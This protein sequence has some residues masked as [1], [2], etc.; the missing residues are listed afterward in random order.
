MAGMFGAPNGITAYNAD[1]RAN[2]QT[3]V[4]AL[5]GLGRVAMQPDQAR[6]LK[7]RADAAEL[8]VESENKMNALMQAAM[9]GQQGEGPQKPRSLASTLDDLAVAA[10]GAGMS[11]KAQEL[12]KTAAG[13]HQKEASAAASL[14]NAAVKRLQFA[15]D[16]A[17]TDAQILGSATDPASWDYANQLYKM[18]TGRPSPYEGQPFDPSLIQQ[19]N[20]AAISAK[21]RASQAE[22]A[23]AHQQLENYR[24][25]RLKQFDTANRIRALRA[26]QAAKREQR[27]E[28]QG[29]GSK[30]ASPTNRE[31]TQTRRL[32]VQQYPDMD[33]ADVREAAFA[34][35]SEAQ[36][37]RNANHALDA[38]TAIRQALNNNASAFLAETGMSANLPLI[39][40]V[41]FGERSQF[42]SGKTPA[43]ARPF[44]ADQKNLQLNHYY[45]NEHGKVFRWVGKGFEAVQ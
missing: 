24:Q 28:K 37:L 40:R 20:D 17:A 36:A 16:S 19:I 33:P 3:G 39:G 1:A 14:A 13:L 29:G 44:P 26:Q 22:T 6:L 5:E 15:R 43:A 9:A 12:A 18:Q 41:G 7:S 31:L 32:I 23:L 42:K 2:L 38:D 25:Q 8:A 30:V 10:A 11:S 35:A 45:V 21:D 4:N 34:I 27:L